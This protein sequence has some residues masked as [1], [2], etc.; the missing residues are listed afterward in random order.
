MFINSDMA[1]ASTMEAT[2][3]AATK[4]HNRKSKTFPHQPQM[5]K[6]YNRRRFIIKSPSLTIMREKR[7]L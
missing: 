5:L 7:E 3:K 2:Q 4:S 1:A 6:Q